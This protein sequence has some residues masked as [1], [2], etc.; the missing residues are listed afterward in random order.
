MIAFPARMPETYPPLTVAIDRS[1]LDQV[2]AGP[3]MNITSPFVS[4]ISSWIV[5]VDPTGRLSE[6]G[7]TCRRAALGDPAQMSPSESPLGEPHPAA[8]R[9]ARVRS[10]ALRR[11]EEVMGDMGPL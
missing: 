11:V 6:S 3:H 9:T 5:S 7:V 10:T 1:L 2:T 8:A 4:C